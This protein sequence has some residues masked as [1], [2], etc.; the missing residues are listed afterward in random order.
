LFDGNFDSGPEMFDARGD[1]GRRIRLAVAAPVAQH[2]A[3]LKVFVALFCWIAARGTLAE[4]MDVKDF[5]HHKQTKYFNLFGKQNPA[6]LEQIGRFADA[7]IVTVHRDFFPAKFDYP[8]RVLVL[9]D[10]SRFQDFVR[11][12]LRVADPPNFGIYFPNFKM[13]V[14][15]EGSGLGTFAHEIMHPL[16]GENFRNLP[17]WAIEGIPSF[18]EKF[19]GYWDNDSIV[20]HW[21]FQNPWRVEALGQNLVRLDLKKLLSTGNSVGDFQESDIRMIS[22]FLWTQGKFQSFLQLQRKDDRHGFN[23]CF[24]A[25]FEKPIDEI[26]PLWTKYL[27]NVANSRPEIMRLPGSVILQNETEFSACVQRTGI[28]KTE[29]TLPTR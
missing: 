23:S 18:F 13:F 16:V 7:F 10:R 29:V 15:Y 5:P 19:Y 9:E 2:P 25:A 20:V 28:L 3:M 14:T 24:E 11:N 1:A 8:I 6:Y 22:M 27:E 17:I 21:G 12:R 26:V 4:E